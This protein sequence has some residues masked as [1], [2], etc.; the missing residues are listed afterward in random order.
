MMTLLCLLL[1]GLGQTGVSL[2]AIRR[3]GRDLTVTLVALLA[4]HV[5][6][7]RLF[8]RGHQYTGRS[9]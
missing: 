7:M 3:G 9:G 6:E 1:A 8:V 2:R 5:E 4:G